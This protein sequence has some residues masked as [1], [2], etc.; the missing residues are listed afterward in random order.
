MP[1]V[2]SHKGLLKRIRVTARGKLKHKRS[3]TSHLNSGKPG[4]KG[5]ELRQDKVVSQSV[6]KKYERAMHCRLK[7]REQA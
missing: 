6:T 4:D 2:K 7:G 5:R 1:K 3:G